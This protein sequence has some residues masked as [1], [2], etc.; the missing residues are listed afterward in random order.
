MAGA[1]IVDVVWNEYE[2]VLGSSRAP[3]EYRTTKDR[4]A[5]KDFFIRIKFKSATQN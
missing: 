2:R 1:G 4:V 5:I 3:T